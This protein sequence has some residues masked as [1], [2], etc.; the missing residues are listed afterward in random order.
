MIIKII[1]IFVKLN[2]IKAIPIIIIG[3]IIKLII[4]GII[5]LNKFILLK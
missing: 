2:I 4:I 3:P 1:C 5:R